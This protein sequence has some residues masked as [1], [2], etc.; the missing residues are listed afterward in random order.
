VPVALGT[1]LGGMVTD[2]AA[3]HGE[4]WYALVPAIGLAIAT[5]LYL[6]ALVA[7]GW[8]AAAALLAAAGFFQYASLGPSFG[9]VQ[10]VVGARRRATATALLYLCLTG[11][12]AAGPLFTG[13]M[14]DHFFAAA[15][16]GSGAGRCGAA[17]AQAS[18]AGII[19][20]LCFHAWA[21]VHYLLGAIGLGRQ[22][23]AAADPERPA[24][25]ARAA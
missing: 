4:R 20:A 19:A 6:L 23:Q 16:P 17:L 22:I 21:A 7:S 13:G 12:L 2:R 24:A 9:V 11:A 5:P 14:I 3:A 15:C 8:Q 25:R 10:N 1:L 18:R